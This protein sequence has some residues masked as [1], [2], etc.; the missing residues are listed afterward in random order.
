MIQIKGLEKSFGEN[1]V[2]RGIDLSPESVQLAV[3][4]FFCGRTDAAQ[5]AEWVIAIL[6]LEPTSS[7]GPT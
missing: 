2:L 1:R 5:A 6:G 3:D 7:N 4:E